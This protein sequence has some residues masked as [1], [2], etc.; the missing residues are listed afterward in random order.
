[1]ERENAAKFERKSLVWLMMTSLKQFCDK[2]WYFFTFFS[3]SD[4]FFHLFA[5]FVS[6]CVGQVKNFD[7]DRD[8]VLHWAEII[9]LK[10]FICM[11]Q[12]LT[13]AV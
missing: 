12:D 9:F 2:K 10:F 3:S 11:K 8:S 4:I 6:S 7:F 1:M 13:D 5:A